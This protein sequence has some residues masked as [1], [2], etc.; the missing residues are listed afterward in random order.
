[1]LGS[2]DSELAVIVEDTKL[3]PSQMNG[4]D[5]QANEFACSL[6]RRCFRSI[7]GYA[8][9]ND[10]IDPVHPKLW[11]EID[12]RVEVDLLLKQRTTLRST[13]SSSDAILITK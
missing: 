12:E 7:F 11:K 13:E 1:M 8:S 5:F 10:V 3:I 4:D 2:R 9:D 6:R